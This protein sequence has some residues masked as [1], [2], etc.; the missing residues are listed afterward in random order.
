M[1]DA[2]LPTFPI[3]IQLKFYLDFTNENGYNSETPFGFLGTCGS[4][5][6]G[7]NQCTKLVTLTSVALKTNCSSSSVNN[8]I[9]KFSGGS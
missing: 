7:S 9:K 6:N 3:L 1:E 4:K 2:V 5:M 8:V